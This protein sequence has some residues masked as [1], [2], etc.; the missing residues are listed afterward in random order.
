M[1]VENLFCSV[2]VLVTGVKYG[3]TDFCNVN[4]VPYADTPYMYPILHYG[5]LPLPFRHTEKDGYIPHIFVHKQVSTMQLWI[6]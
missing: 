4:L 6:K 1:A 3:P 5:G 2:S